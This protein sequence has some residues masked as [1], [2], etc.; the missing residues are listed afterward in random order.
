[1]ETRKQKEVEY[2]DLEAEQSSVEETKEAG[3]KA[4]LGPFLLESY[5]FLYS[6]LN[7]RCRGGKILLKLFE[8]MDR[9]GIFVSPFL[10]EYSF[11]TAF[12]FY[13]KKII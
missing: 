4:G 11:K 13:G 10:K 1:M 3:S 7:S 12:I 2:Y 9:L 5:R 6:L 8:R